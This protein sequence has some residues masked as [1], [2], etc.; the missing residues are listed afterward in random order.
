M[1]LARGIAL[2]AVISILDGPN[3]FAESESY[4][5]IRV[6]AGMTGSTVG[7]SG[8]NGAGIVME[9]KAMVTDQLAIGGRVADGALRRRRAADRRRRG[10][11]RTTGHSRRR[12]S[13]AEDGSAHHNERRECCSAAG[14][15]ARLI[16]ARSTC[17][18]H[19]LSRANASPCC[20]TC[21]ALTCHPL[22]RPTGAGRA[23]RT[24]SP[25][26]RQLRSRPGVSFDSV[27]S[28]STT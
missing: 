8:R 1:S 25:T 18:S 12:S 13:S 16:S 7:V 2:L 26:S 5:Q 22:S 10:Y 14:Y 9:I 27:R 21:V 3:A 24:M 11:R 28:A 19:G 4:E 6:D 17:R 23:A 20:A 15:I